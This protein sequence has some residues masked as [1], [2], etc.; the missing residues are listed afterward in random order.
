MKR[1]LTSLLSALLLVVSGTSFFG[2]DMGIGNLTN[3][4]TTNPTIPDYNADIQIVAPENIEMEHFVVDEN[5]TYY[6]SPGFSLSIEINGEFMVMD[7]FSIEG[8]KRVYDN[9]YLYPDD[10][11]FMLT[12]DY[13][14]LYASLGDSADFEYAEEEKQSGED[15]QINVKKAGIYKLTFDVK[16]LKF[17]MEYK[18]EIQTPVYYTIKNCSIYSV[19][20]SWVEMS[21]NPA[22]TDEFVIH[23]YSVEAGK[24]ISFFSNLHISNYKVTL[25]ESIDNKLAAVRKT[26]VTV[27]VGGAYNIYIN[28]KTYVVRME[29]INP[30]TATYGCVYYDGTDFITLEPYEADVPYIF[31]QRIVVTTQYTT[32][33]PKFHSTAYRTY[34]L[35]V[36]DPTDVLMGSGKYYYFKQPGTYDVIINLKTFEITAELLP[37]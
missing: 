8:D 12:D 25:D 4:G 14:Y 9:L 15:V 10:Y 29:L 33:L 11:F 6:T 22:N 2:C 28:K 37:E 27:N 26:D 35:T 30:D 5:T 34:D 17:D 13:K 1:K 23:N 36:V 18:A 20:T 19:A 21:E 24:V 7:Y 31:R 32:D 16:T 3:T